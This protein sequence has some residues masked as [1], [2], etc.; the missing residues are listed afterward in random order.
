M[1]PYSSLQAE[2]AAPVCTGS[3]REAFWVGLFVSIGSDDFDLT[4]HICIDFHAR[5]SMIT[6]SV[7]HNSVIS[8]VSCSIRGSSR[9]PEG[10]SD[11]MAL[12]SD[13]VS[14]VQVGRAWFP[15]GS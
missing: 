13:R 2:R 1:A 15:F 3:Y 7:R 14:V 9:A 11:L 4:G 8:F 6:T 10:V 5:N 12:R